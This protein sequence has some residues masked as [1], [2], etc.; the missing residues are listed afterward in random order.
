MAAG[1]YFGLQPRPSPTTLPRDAPLPDPSAPP[2]RPAS[3]PSAIVQ[4]EP[5]ALER[6]VGAAL[7]Q[8]RAT[9][10]ERCW[11]PEAA[12][13]AGKAQFRLEFTF[14]ADGRQLGRGVQEVRGTSHPEVTR[15]LLREL[16]PLALRPLGRGMATAVDFQLP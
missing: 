10:V 1:L 3:V 4:V 9:L 11:R 5:L 8:H 7:E 15:C 6:L 13:A 16:P 2:R 14:G 12:G